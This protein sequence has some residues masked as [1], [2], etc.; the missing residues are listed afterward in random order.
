MKQK[1]KGNYM[2]YPE[3]ATYNYYVKKNGKEVN[4]KN[5]SP[6]EQEFAEKW[7]YST[8]IRGLGGSQDRS[9]KRSK[10]GSS[11]RGMEEEQ[12]E[13]L[14]ILIKDLVQLE[15]QSLRILQF[16]ADILGARE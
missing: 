8:L 7:V 12:R 2:R 16:A 9:D 14:E 1:G 5:L 13:Q 4:V 11:N 3:K 15:K 6:E 10:S